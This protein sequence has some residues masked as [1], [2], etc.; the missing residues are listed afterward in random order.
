MSARIAGLL[1]IF[2]LTAAPARC[3]GQDAADSPDEAALTHQQW[4]RRVEDARRR[5]E[6]FVANARTQ[7]ATSAPFDQEQTEAMDRAEATDR[8]MNDP[9]LRQGDIIATGKGFVVFVGRD[10]A[11]HADDFRSAPNQQHPP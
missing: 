11:H 8:A 1:V 9:T 7:A 2:F 3:F 6:E 4:Q 10:E 5:S